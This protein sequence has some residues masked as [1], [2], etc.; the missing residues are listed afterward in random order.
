MKQLFYCCFFRKKKNK[1][2]YK[3]YNFNEKIRNYPIEEYF[4]N[5]DLEHKYILLFEK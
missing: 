1:N 2:K 4:Y 3:Y 5:Q